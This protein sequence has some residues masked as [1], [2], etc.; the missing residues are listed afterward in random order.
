MTVRILLIED[1]RTFAAGLRNNLEIEGYHVECE[2]GG[3]RGLAR[4]RA[5][6]PDLI[7]LDLTLPDLD[8]HRVLR[9]LRA[10][11]C[12]V[13]VLIL[14]ARGDEADKIL[15]F[16]QGADD[17][18][19]K[20]FGLL[21]LLA[22]IE[23]LLRRARGAHLGESDVR[24]GDVAVSPSRRVVLRSG[25]EVPLRPKELDL[26][27][28]L[29]RRM[30]QV[31]PRHELLRQ[32]WGYDPTVVSRTLDTHILELRQKLE[33]EPSNPRHIVTVRKSGYRLVP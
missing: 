17:Y 12:T 31:V 5:G 19:T 29:C 10:E 22:R 24:F 2:P 8:G 6:R 18:V 9:T 32:V 33:P 7:I 1:N 11:G 26:L 3:R 25:I 30:D 14:S 4:A 20:P 23:A 27:L 21:E 13:P 28:E 16:R 15:G